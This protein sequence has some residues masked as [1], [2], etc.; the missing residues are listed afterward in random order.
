MSTRLS[1]IGM[2][3]TRTRERL[4]Q[5]LRDL[6]IVDENVL[7]AM[8]QVPRHVFVDEALASRTYEDTALPIGQGQTISQPYIVARM[9]QLLFANG[10]RRVLEIGTGCGYQTAILCGLARE[11]YSVERLAPLHQSARRL[12]QELGYLNFRLKLGDGSAGWAEYAPYD[13]ILVTA[14]AADVPMELLGQLAP[15]GQ[16][17][18]PVGNALRQKLFSIRLTEEGYVRERLE[19]VNFVPLIRDAT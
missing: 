16:L 2:T 4:I 18:I 14:A 8:N 9:T 3:S 10:A 12:L 7:A 17:V 19:T 11:V 13:G 6:G 5:R 1:G 15:G